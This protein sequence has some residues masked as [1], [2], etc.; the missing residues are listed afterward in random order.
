MIHLIH[1]AMIAERKHYENFEIVGYFKYANISDTAQADSH[2]ENL[3]QVL[4]KHNIEH[5][6]F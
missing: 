5:K 3:T 2:K 1:A 6:W 4:T